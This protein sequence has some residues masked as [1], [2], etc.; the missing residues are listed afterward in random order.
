MTNTELTNVTE[1]V[2]LFLFQISILRDWRIHIAN[3]N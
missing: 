3:F 1:S 2:C